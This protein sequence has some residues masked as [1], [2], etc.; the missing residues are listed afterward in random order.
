MT[1]IRWRF[2]CLRFGLPPIS[3]SGLIKATDQLV[4][5][6]S[7]LDPSD[8]ELPW[9]DANEET[10]DFIDFWY[11]EPQK[12]DLRAVAHIL[13]D[14]QGHISDALRVAV[15]RLIITK[16]R[17]ASIAG[18]VPH[19]RPHRIQET[20]DFDVFSELKKAAK[21]LADRLTSQVP[22]GN[23]EVNIGD[24]RNLHDLEDGSID[25]VITSPPYLNAIDYLRGHR[26]SLVWFG[27]TM[28]GLREIRSET[29]GVE[30]VPNPK[31]DI[32]LATS[33]TDEMGELEELPDRKRRMILR[34]A[35]D[36]HYTLK[37]VSR[38]IKKGGMSVLVI[39]NSTHRGIFVKNTQAVRKAAELNGLILTDEVEREIPPS[40]R[41]LPPPSEMSNSDLKK[42]MRTESILTFRKN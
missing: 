23:V 11:V 1:W 15:S 36:I 14:Q 27:H 17:G 26:L 24:A 42:R 20:N 3:S 12:S 10:R 7:S 37:E 19:S 35:L 40:R 34:Y 33:I 5:S 29:V 38:V 28:K 25:A 39:G 22:P 2:Y 13:K 21:K 31:S 41:Y 16:T 6:A 32:D 18:D 9:I 4:N 30:R 8:I